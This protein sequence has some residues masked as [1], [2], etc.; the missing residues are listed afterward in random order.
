MKKLTYGRVKPL[1]VAYKIK[2]T[3][4]YATVLVCFQSVVVV[5]LRWQFFLCLYTI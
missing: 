5:I 2:I 4:K 1:L 3:V